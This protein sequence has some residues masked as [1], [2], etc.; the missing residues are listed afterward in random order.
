VPDFILTGQT[1]VVAGYSVAGERI[2]VIGPGYRRPGWPPDSLFTRGGTM[3]RVLILVAFAAVA[4]GCM[5]G[6][7]GAQQQP[8]AAA[9]QSPTIK[10][11]PLQKYDVP[12]A[13]MEMVLGI[14]EI[15]PDVLIARHTHPGME[16]GYVLEGELVLMIDGQAPKTL[17]AGDSYQIPLEAIHDA[18]SGPS[19]AKVLAVYVV[20]KG[21]PLASPAK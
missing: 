10:R 20:R 1:T 5:P 18:K 19:G 21:E 13:P 7:A 15:V 12:G 2:F 4:I 16:G 17:K 9:N 3:K 8:P 11:T 14:A 6:L